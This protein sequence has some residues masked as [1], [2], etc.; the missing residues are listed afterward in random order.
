MSCGTLHCSKIWHHLSCQDLITYHM[1][2]T[3]GKLIWCPGRM[4]YPELNLLLSLSRFGLQLMVLFLYLFS[5]NYYLAMVSQIGLFSW[6]A[7][8]ECVLTIYKFRNH[9]FWGFTPDHCLF[10]ASIF[11]LINQVFFAC[12]FFW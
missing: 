2:H 9:C 1:H 5:R 3:F 8:S 11:E 12:L 6:Y 10:Y 4:D 7:S